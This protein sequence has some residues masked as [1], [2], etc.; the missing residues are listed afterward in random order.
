M[1]GERIFAAWIR[2]GLALVAG[3]LAAARLLERDRTQRCVIVMHALGRY[4]DAKPYLDYHN[5]MS[6]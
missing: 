3:G 2:T 1:A 5:W 6:T 4:H